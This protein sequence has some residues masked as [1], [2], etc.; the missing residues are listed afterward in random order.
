MAQR[1][2]PHERAFESFLRAR[3]IPYV[4]VDEAKK[5]LLPPG[6]HGAAIGSDDEGD[7]ALKSFDF[8]L[9]GQD[10]ENLLV[11]VKGRKLGGG[12]GSAAT[13]SSAGRMDS[14][15]PLDDVTS[16]R[17]WETLFGAGFRAA[18]VFVYWCAEQPPDALFQEIMEY[19]GDWY[20][21]RAVSLDAYERSMKI[22]SPKWRTVDIPRAVFQRISQPLAPSVAEN[23]SRLA[24]VSGSGSGGGGG[25]GVGAGGPS[26]LSSW[27]STRA[28]HAPGAWPES[29][30]G[31]ET[32]A[33]RPLV[34]LNRVPR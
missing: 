5:A 19:Q 20:A 8:V 17:R 14:W 24:G 23:W 12:G 33:L 30:P 3:R 31:P 27:S 10:G 6:A 34:R 9:Y 26:S 11:D 15:V 21:L 13:S 29:G 2:Y 28:R 16:L 32:P 25:G 22:R 18:F 7:Q 1:R 4:A